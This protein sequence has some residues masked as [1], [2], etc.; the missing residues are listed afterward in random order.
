[1]KVKTYIFL[2][3]LLAV[4][5]GFYFFRDT[6]PEIKNVIIISMD[7]T[8]ADHL[9]CYGYPVRTT[10]NIDAIAA[11]GILFENTIS[12]AP[13]TLPAHSTM[14]TGTIPPYHG[15]HDNLDYTLA[16][17]NITLPEILKENGFTTGALI[18]TFVLDSRFGLNQGFDTY[19]DIFEEEHITMSFN[20]RKGDEATR[21]AID[22]LD[23][24]K[25]ERF[26][27]FLHYYD[28]HTDYSPPE[29]FALNFYGNP[30]AGEIAFTD[31]CIGQ[32]ID[33]LKELDLYD[34]AL[35]V[36]AGDHGE[37]LGEHGEIT[38]AY[39]IYQSAIRVP[40]IF[41]LPGERIGKRITG[42]SGLVDIVPTICGLLGIETDIPFAGRDL[43]SYL[44][45]K[46]KTPE[47]RDVFCES[48]MPT[49]YNANNLL[50]L[51]SGNWKYIQTTRPELYDLASDPGEKNNLYEQQFNRARIL[52][53]RLK[54]ILETQVRKSDPESKLELDEE[55][56]KRLES[57]GYIAGN[58]VSE[59]F[60]FDQSKEDPKDLIEFHTDNSKVGG[61]IYHKKFEKAKAVLKK[62][63]LQRPD[64]HKTYQHLGKIALKQEDFTGAILHFKKALEL[65]PDQ[66]DLH[67]NL[68]VVY[69]DSGRFEEAVS[70]FNESLRLRPGKA[71]PLI[72]LGFILMKQ[73]KFDESI[74][75]FQ[76]A[77]EA[78]PRNVRA[79]YNMGVAL[80]AQEKFDEA[81]V[82]LQKAL[83]IDKDNFK[84]H[85][86]LAELLFNM[87]KYDA[88]IEHYHEAIRL[89]P[90]SA[91]LYRN[92]GIV[93]Q[94]QDRTDEAI[95]SYKESI[96]LDPNQIDLIYSLGLLLVEL[97]RPEDAL[98]MY[99]KS[100][101]LKSDRPVVHKMVADVFCKQGKYDEAIEEYNE[102][103]S[104][105]PEMPLVLNNLAEVYL[106]KGNMEL[107]VGRWQQAI[108][109]SPKWPEVL[110]NLAWCKSVYAGSSF[111]DPSKAVE[112]GEGAC[113]LTE[114]KNADF[115]DTLS[116][117]Y[118]AEG[119]FSDAVDTANKALG[120]ANDAGQE[121]VAGQIQEHL[122]L[123]EAGKPYTEDIDQ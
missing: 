83:E 13:M 29:P 80:V 45:K 110:N 81:L 8:R 104:L 48:L 76:K 69:M 15:I 47:A 95:G 121:Q 77:I 37:M 31:H 91:A 2:L 102:A 56:I 98:A 23:E 66:F 1:M 17:S 55:A 87:E 116:I 107:A 72:N 30:Y 85:S 59:D 115:L 96:E 52:K 36:I 34:S 100:L 119:R 35:I 39:F 49:K 79:Y 21:L 78:D 70:S 20:E 18:G 28:P 10:P 108:D 26:F 94:K 122:K 33:K 19:N 60:S 14:L 109:I 11:E 44:G 54:E 42:L 6:G 46:G 9:S 74:A 75:Y 16:G 7:T 62:M 64:F 12:P 65:K 88:A 22:W 3:M 40:M 53:D 111:Y 118:A 63:L 86:G 24:H 58:S 27:Y 68:G 82:Q 112:Y 99:R 103:L 106:A 61:F 123:F 90:E 105:K 41:K 97:E 57:L 113:E 89:D 4:A 71:Q 38:H 84:V 101:K 93:L 67:T 5:G 51:V 120:L 43:S 117:A 32:V 50:G 25:D 73:E 114:Y 92:L